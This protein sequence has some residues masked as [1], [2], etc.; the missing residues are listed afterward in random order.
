MKLQLLIPQYQETDEIIRP[1]LDSIALQQ[2]VDFDEVGV[3]IVNDGSRVELS[4]ELPG[5]Y[6]FKINYHR[7]AHA[8]VSATRNAALDLAA[9]DYVMFCDAD[10][11]FCHVCGLW[12]IMREIESGFDALASSF[13]EETRRGNQVHYIGHNNDATFVHGKVYRRQF[14][15]ENGI[16]WNE[17]LTIHEDS[18][19]NVLAQSVAGK[20]RYVH[21]PFYLWKWRDA[22]V[23]RHDP[24]YPLK[25]YPQLIDSCEALVEEFERRGDHEKAAFHVAVMVF[26]A[27]YTMNKPAWL[28]QDN[29]AY[30]DATEFH[31]SRFFARWRSAWEGLGQADKMKIC[32]DIRERAV[33]QGM[34]M[35]CITLEHWLNKIE[36]I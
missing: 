13:L 3:I 33:G 5:S 8:G 27:Y 24:E 10:D 28:N 25:T 1:L 36:N 16:R 6:P 4:S 30:R 14:L 35:E 20:V 34:A 31:F 18:F 26:D 17:A 21:T 19:F 9:A 29:R 32:G 2:N 12:A 11:M 22:S 23:C 15:E 7:R